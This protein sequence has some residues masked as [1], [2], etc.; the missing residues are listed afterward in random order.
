MPEVPTP[1]IPKPI[2]PTPVVPPPQAPD[3]FAPP[4]VP[5]VSLRKKV[6]KIITWVF[7][8]FC[9]TAPI[10]LGF[11]WSSLLIV[12]VGTMALP[13][14]V[15]QNFWKRMIPA[16]IGFL[17]P[18]VLAIAFIAAVGNAPSTDTLPAAS[19][20]SS[21]PASSVQ[22]VA[23][24][25]TSVPT[26]VPTEQPTAVPTEAPTPE[27]TPAPTA[28]PTQVPATQAPAAAVVPVPATN[29]DNSQ[30]VYWT[31][32]GKSYHF[33][34]NCSTLSRSKTILS[35]TLQQALDAGKTDPCDICAGG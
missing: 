35:G 1:E 12:I 4:D 7:C 9:F 34:Q 28:A 23:A 22:A 26:A 2:F 21:Y 11:C 5:E 20:G 17:K 18:M 15:M 16:Q 3:P 8:V 24:V 33:D 27:P 14:D 29:A 19:S 10:G 6:L 32:N 30:T 31:P 25:Q 13:I